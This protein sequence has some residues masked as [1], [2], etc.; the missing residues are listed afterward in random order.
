MIV[1]VPKRTGQSQGKYFAPHT[2][3]KLCGVKR[4]GPLRY[5][6]LS[7]KCPKKNICAS[8]LWHLTALIL[9]SHQYLPN[10]PNSLQ[11][12]ARVWN[13][14]DITILN[15]CA[16]TCLETVYQQMRR[17][18]WDA[19]RK[20]YWTLMRGNRGLQFLVSNVFSM[21][22]P[23]RLATAAAGIKKFNFAPK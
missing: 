7:R 9:F 2:V 10:I 21:Y 15:L 20:V 1:P 11:K 18:C 17:I 16:N 8:I 23:Q 22:L 3:Y 5:F 19:V 14:P 12:I 13:F 4:K 6:A